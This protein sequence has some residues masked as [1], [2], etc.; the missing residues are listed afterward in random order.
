MPPELDEAPAPQHSRMRFELIL[1][2]LLLALGLFVLPA[3]IF[4][5]GNSMLGP[6]GTGSGGT[7]GTFYGEFFG[8]MASGAVRPWCLALGPLFLISLVRLIFIRRPE[9]TTDTPA[10]T[11]PRHVASKTPV[12]RRVEP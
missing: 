5:V 4:W 1:A 12:D 7:L 3:V 9:E 2:S 10:P 11:A 8:D 6:Y